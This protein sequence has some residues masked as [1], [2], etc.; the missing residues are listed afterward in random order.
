MGTYADKGNADLMYLYSYRLIP[1]KLVRDWK[2]LFLAGQPREEKE[3]G[4]GSADS[5]TS[6]AS[7]EQESNSQLLDEA[8]LQDYLVM[9]VIICLQCAK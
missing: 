6:S 3:E 7:Y 9:N 8:D 5:F 4:K 2:T 1:A